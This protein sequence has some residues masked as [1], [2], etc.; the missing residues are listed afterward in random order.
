LQ[1][2]KNRFS[3]VVNAAQQTGPQVVTRRGC[4]TVVVI[5]FDDYTKLE[6]RRTKSSIGELLRSAPK[7]P[8]GLA[9]ERPS[10]LGRDVELA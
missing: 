4:D 8:G 1:D 6:R 7:L 2:A 3:E 10:D 9:S 5:S